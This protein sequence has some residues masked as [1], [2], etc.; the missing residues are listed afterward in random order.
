MKG[1]RHWVY[2]EQACII[3]RK[4]H[5]KLSSLN[6]NRGKVC[7]HTYPI[8][9]LALRILWVGRQGPLD[10]TISVN[11]QNP[12]ATPYYDMDLKVKI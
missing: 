4:G 1:W 8:C 3:D 9:V 6:Q 7:H 12:H 5:A 10:S 11:S 2:L